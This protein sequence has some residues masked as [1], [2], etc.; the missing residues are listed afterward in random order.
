MILEPTVFVLG[1]GASCDYRFPAGK[2]VVEIITSGLKDPARGAFWDAVRRCGFQAGLMENFCR[3]LVEADPES[4][5]DFLIE[6]RR[7]Y[8]ELGKTCIALAVG[9]CERADGSAS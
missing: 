4:I 6:N 3:D 8:L 5:D 7:H 1:A 9:A 2:K